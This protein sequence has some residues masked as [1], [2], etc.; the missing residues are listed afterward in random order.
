MDLTS[1]LEREHTWRL[2]KSLT[3]SR[4]SKVLLVKARLKRHQIFSA[5]LS[6]G[7]EGVMNKGHTLAGQRNRRALWNA[8]L[9]RSMIL[10]SV[11]RSLAKWSRKI[12]KVVDEQC[13][14]S[15]W[16]WSPEMGEYAPKSQVDRKTCWKAQTGLTPLAVIPLPARVK[17][18]KRLSS[19]RRRS[20]LAACDLAIQVHV[21]AAPWGQGDQFRT[22]LLEVF[23]K[24]ATASGS[25]FTCDLRA[26][27]H[28]AP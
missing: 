23:L 3:W 24:A 25:F 2:M 18:P 20:A 26:T 4:V 10:N 1:A 7:A 14:S 11:G 27:L 15:N 21:G 8:P 19:R 16:K 6:S 5:G 9:S 22:A 28:W 13:G 17:R 12:W